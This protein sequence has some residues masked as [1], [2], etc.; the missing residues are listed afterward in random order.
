M[1]SEW[2]DQETRTAL[3]FLNDEEMA[4]LVAACKSVNLS[5]GDILF[6]EREPA[7]DVYFLVSGRLAVRKHTGFA[8]KLQVVALLDAGA[9]VGEC[10]AVPGLER[11]ATVVAVG[12]CRLLALDSQNIEMLKKDNPSVAWKI[13][14]R[15]LHV[16]H[17]RLK[18]NSERLAHVM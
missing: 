9:P 13:L 7:T 12:N 16:S 17:L 1:K 2:I 8:D 14:T 11:G 10:A 5:A 6:R 4:V 15:L 3:A 18:K